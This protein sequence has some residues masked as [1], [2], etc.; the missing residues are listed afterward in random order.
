MRNRID[1][2]ALLSA[3]AAAVLLAACEPPPV[4]TVQRG[5]RGTGM[6]EL[7]PTGRALRRYSRTSR[8]SAT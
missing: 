3:L 6:V 4:K 1:I 2:A 8:C 7:R 5:Y